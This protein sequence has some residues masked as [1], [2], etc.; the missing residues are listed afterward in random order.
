MR[1]IFIIS[2]TL[3]LFNYNA[4]AQQNR[5]E[6]IKAYKTAF[7]TEKLDLSSKEAE[8]FWPIYN[9][10]NKKIHQLKYSSSHKIRKEIHVKGGLDAL[11]EKE[12]D[13]YL[14][15]LLQFEQEIINTK[16]NFY[17][18]IKTVISSNKV[19]ILYR[20]EFEFNR[21]LLSE[22]RKKQSK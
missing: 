21:K 6:K 10:Y 7:L 3:L 14:S 20:A 22:F 16:M 11:S 15:N 13:Q 18:D 8:S 17:K 1:F 12:A 2:I 19:L 4:Q 9:A 5:H